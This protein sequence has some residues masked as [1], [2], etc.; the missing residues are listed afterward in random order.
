MAQIVHRTSEHGTR[1]LQK[2]KARTRI[3]VGVGRTFKGDHE[4]SNLQNR[5]QQKP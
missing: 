3:N 2:N 5:K 1:N 4:R